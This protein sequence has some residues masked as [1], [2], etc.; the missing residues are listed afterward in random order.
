MSELVAASVRLLEECNVEL[1]P[2]LS[3]DELAAVERRYGIRFGPDH[4]QLLLR[5]VPVGERWV[6]WR[7]APE[8]RIAEQLAWPIDGA[9]FDVRHNAFWAASWGPRADVEADAIRVAREHL[10]RWPRLLPLYGHRYLPAAPS[11]TGAPV[12]SVHQTDVI[13]YGANLLDY[14]KR[15]FGGQREIGA[16]ITVDVPPWS[17]LAMSY[18][19][20]DL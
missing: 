9:L 8:E 5:A 15:E 11:G 17:L 14:L 20:A 19:G 2:G 3:S 12:F 6:D 16:P 18:D 13:Y 7:G 10:E 4:R 1:A